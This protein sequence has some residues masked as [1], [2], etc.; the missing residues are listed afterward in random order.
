MLGA[1]SLLLNGGGVAQLK[2]IAN[3]LNLALEGREDSAK[4]VLHQVESLVSQLDDHKGDIVNAIESLNRLAISARGHQRSI[5]ARWRSCRVLSTR[6]GVSGATWSGCSQGLNRL[7][8]VG[9]RVIRQTKAS[10]I[11]ILQQLDPVLSAVNDAGDDFVDVAPPLR[12]VPVLRRRHRSGPGRRPQPALRR[13]REPV[14]RARPQPQRHRRR[15]PASRSACCL[16]TPRSTTCSTCL[17]SA[18]ASLN[19]IQDCLGPPPDLAAC[20]GLLPRPARRGLR[21][22]ADPRAHPVPRRSVVA[23]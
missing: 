7:S 11:D 15:S 21:L 20:T 9:V 2:T 17:G 10:T 14:D 6:S 1:L 16:P 4:S 12:D 18:T 22:G 3:E 5:D 8:T 23:A 19:A 13:L